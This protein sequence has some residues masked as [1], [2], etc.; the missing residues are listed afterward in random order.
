MGDGMSTLL[1]GTEGGLYEWERAL[2]PGRPVTAL[3]PAG[4]GGWVALVGGREVWTSP[5]TVVAHLEGGPEGRCLMGTGDGIL[6]GTAGAHLVRVAPR[7]GVVE[8]VGTFD[9]AP[10]RDTWYT[11]WGGPPDTRS[12][13]VGPDGTVYANVHVG[14]ILRAS[15]GAG[16]PWE[17]TIDVDADVHQVLAVDADRV[18][19][20]CAL[21]LA[22]S[23]DGGRTWAI[24]TDGLHAPY[25]RAV[26][27]A[28]DQLLLSAS[29]GPWTDRAAVYR[30]P[31]AGGEPFERVT[32]WFGENVDTGCL[33]A[34]GDEVAVGVGGTVYR[35]GDGGGTW[36]V[37]AADLPPVT[38]VALGGR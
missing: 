4:D 2:I 29:T 10:G 5:G 20:A 32:D 30:R 35:S 6:V 11:P 14:G 3:A 38:A 37:A 9:A 22:T 19:A 24:E 33:A 15:G 17:P 8:T 21:G 27:V 28:G 13:S 23:T 26:A 16:G 12:L 34:A 25:A 36:E 31:L 18:V 7:G 1:I